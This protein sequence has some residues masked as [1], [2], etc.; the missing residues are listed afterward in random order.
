MELLETDDPI[1]S[2]L[3]KKSAQH[4]EELEQDVQLITER[5]QRVVT[6]ALII[7]GAL[8]LTYFMVR[9]FSGSKKK[10]KGK[11]KKIRVVNATAEPEAFEQVEAN[12]APGFVAQIGT[13]LASQASVFLLSLAK[14][15]L[16]EYLQSQAEKKEQK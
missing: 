14:E 15:K 5:T 9:Q 3:L 12:A 2:Q 10:S 16:S 1:K 13:A 6:N 8:A 4:R 11:T 7:G